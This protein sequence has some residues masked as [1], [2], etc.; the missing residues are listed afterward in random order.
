MSQA[1]LDMP[2]LDAAADWVI[3]MYYETPDLATQQAFKHWLGQSEAHAQAWAR[4]QALLGSFDRVP[5]G[6][7]QDVLRARGRG[8]RVLLR[9]MAGGLIVLPTAW[10]M[11]REA[12]RWAADFNTSTGERRTWSLIDGSQLVLNTHSAVNVRF[13]DTQRRLVLVSGEVLVTTG[14]DSVS[15]YRPFLIQTPQGEV[16]ALGTRFRVRQ[17]D[18]NTQVS[19]FE[20]AVEL[21]PSDGDPMRLTAGQE[22][23]FTRERVGDT[24]SVDADAIAWERGM[25][26]VRDWRLADV[27]AE[28]DRY[29]PGVLRCAAEVASLRVSG[30]LSVSDTDA[31]LQALTV[32]LPISVHRISPYWVTVG[33]QA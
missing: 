14:P 31:A 22:A 19:V 23:V 4:A 28:L 24:Q 11:G 33:L 1:R 3:R 13:T 25:M 21:R 7:G 15:H 12:P 9:A 17:F 27:I 30:A 32:R 6:I 16:Q 10:L 29:R 2:L 26:V 5:A 20:H 8:R 18:G